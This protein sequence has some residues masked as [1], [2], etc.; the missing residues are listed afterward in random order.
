VAP[1]LF[2]AA[3]ADKDG[4]VTQAELKAAFGKWYADADAAK[5]GTITQ[6]QLSAVLAAALP[7]PP[8]DPAAAPATTP[9]AGARGAGA[10]APG[11]GASIEPVWGSPTPGLNDPCGGRGQTPTVACADDI[12][13]MIAA[14]PATAPAKP[15]KARKVLI[16]SRVP[17]AGWQHSSIPLAARTIEELGKKTGAWTSVTSWDPGVFTTEYLKQFDAIFLSNTVGCFLDKAG[18]KAADGFLA[19]QRRIP[20]TLSVSGATK[21]GEMGVGGVPLGNRV[22]RMTP[23]SPTSSKTSAGPGRETST[24]DS[25][26]REQTGGNG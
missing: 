2:T 1:L 26:G 13:K 16:W 15:E 14:L 7:T 9:A 21:F 5:A 23:T 6:E 18:D 10:P 3:D 17:S 11:G 24:G 19:A 20:D 8:P 12:T 25:S 4:G 22:T